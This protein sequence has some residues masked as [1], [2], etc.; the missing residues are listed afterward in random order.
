MASWLAW[1]AAGGASVALLILSATFVLGM[2][3]EL[4]STLGP[5]SYAIVASVSVALEVAL[6][7]LALLIWVDLGRR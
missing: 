1:L 6:A 2:L 7:A 5:V 4:R 3:L